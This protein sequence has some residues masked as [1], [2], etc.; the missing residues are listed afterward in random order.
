MRVKDSGM[1][2][3]HIHKL[4]RHRHSTGSV[5]YFCVEP[6]CTYKVKPAL[7]LGKR[8]ICWRCEGP[9]IMNEYS[10]RL[11]KPHCSDCHKPKNEINEEPV[12]VMTVPIVA[13]YP[14]KSGTITSIP[15]SASDLRSRLSSVVQEA[16]EGE[17]I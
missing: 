13:T 8:A 6:D 17:D 15:N 16:E 5:I 11:A 2:D 12:A 9:F 10:I 14:N 4:R 1:K 7:S 3:K